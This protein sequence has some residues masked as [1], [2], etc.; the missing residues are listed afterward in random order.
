MH[1]RRSVARGL[2]D[3][4]GRP[5]CIAVGD[6]SAPTTAWPSAGLRL[7]PLRSHFA[8]RARSPHRLHFA[9]AQARFALRARS[10]AALHFVAAQGLALLRH[11]GTE[12]AGGMHEGAWERGSGHARTTI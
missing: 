9:L 11:P 2:V 6:L 12:D 4:A 3:F 7:D 10:L 5:G 1:S 8:L